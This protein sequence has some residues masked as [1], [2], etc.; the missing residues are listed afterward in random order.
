MWITKADG[1]VLHAAADL[2][3][4]EVAH[5]PLNTILLFG[6]ERQGLGST[7]MTKGKSYTGD[8]LKVKSIDPEAIGWLFA[9]QY[10]GNAL[11]AEVADSALVDAANQSGRI[12]AP[13]PMWSNNEVASLLELKHLEGM[14]SGYSGFY[15][16]KRDAEGIETLDGKF[17][18]GSK[19]DESAEGLSIAYSGEYA[20]GKHKGNVTGVFL[21]GTQKETIWLDYAADG[22]FK[23]RRYQ[24]EVGAKVEATYSDPTES[25]DRSSIEMDE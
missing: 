12:I 1:L 5:L 7:I 11:A 22:K 21:Q 9:G 15:E 20:A 14:E 3:S 16:F 24:L 8:W 18:I 4:A 2:H 25:L 6:G 23:G 19:A 17:W 10:R 13:I